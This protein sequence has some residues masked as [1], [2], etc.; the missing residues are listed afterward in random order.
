[1]LLFKLERGIDGEELRTFP[2]LIFL[3]R[4]LSDVVTDVDVEYENDDKQV[5]RLSDD[6]EVVVIQAAAAAAAL[7]VDRVSVTI[8]FTM[9]NEWRIIVSALVYL[10][11]IV[12]LNSFVLFLCNTVTSIAL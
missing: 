8:K 9:L 5:I 12:L 10:P 6:E 11:I 1:L 3:L 2:R 7:F 4:V